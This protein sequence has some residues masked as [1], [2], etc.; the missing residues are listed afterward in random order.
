M[1]QRIRLIATQEATG[2]TAGAANRA[3][4]CTTC[5]YNASYSFG[6]VYFGVPMRT[7][8]TISSTEGTNYYRIFSD[9]GSDLFDNVS[10]QSSSPEAY[11]IQFYGN[12]SRTAGSGSWAETENAATRVAFSAEF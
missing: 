9:G 2:A 7:S 8:P 3:P 11:C 12:L 1:S 6:V 5:N 10:L 4:I